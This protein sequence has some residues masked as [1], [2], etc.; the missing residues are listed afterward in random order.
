MTALSDELCTMRACRDAIEWV[1]DRDARTAWRECN[2][3]DA[4]D[5]ADAAARLDWLRR[6][7]PMVRHLVPWRLVEEA[8]RA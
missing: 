5:A 6:A 8:R 3:A 2:R 1:G 7:A 4:V